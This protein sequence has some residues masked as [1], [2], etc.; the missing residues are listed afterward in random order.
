MALEVPYRSIPDMFLKRV[1]A[2]PG[3]RA[4]AAPN[5]D[6]TDMVWM[7]WSEVGDRAKA[8]AHYQQHIEEV[9]AAV[10]PGRL[11]VF[12]VDQGWEPLCQ[13]LGVAV[14][15][16]PFPNVN[17][18][19]A[20][21]EVIAKLTKA[22]GVGAKLTKVEDAWKACNWGNYQGYNAQLTKSSQ[23]IETKKYLDFIKSSAVA[24]LRT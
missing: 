9:K 22:T 6:D 19:A 8:I 24:K 3:G 14:P 15:S 7:T 1:A 16:T 10:P 11:L 18:R 17:D 4:F 13:F 2:T 20:I 23:D 5:A 21:K 12:S